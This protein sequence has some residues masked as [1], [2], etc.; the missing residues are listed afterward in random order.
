MSDVLNAESML[1][2]ALAQAPGLSD[3]GDESFR[4]GL[5]VL[6]RSLA[7]DA[8]L[9]ELGATLL[10]QKI[11]TQLANRLRIEDYFARHPEIADEAIAPPLFIVGV[12]R[13]G[14]TKLH[15]LL[16]C[17]ERF[18]WMAFWESQFPVPFP[19]E[20][21][22]NPEARRRQG[23]ELV[24]M[25]TQAMPKLLAIHPMENEAADEEVMLMEHSMLSAFNAYAEVPGYMRWLD[26]SDQAPAYRYL[27]RMLQFLQWQK[28]KRGIAAQRW[29]LKAPHHLLRMHLL[30]EVFP[31]AQVILTHR[32]PVQS[33]P[34][35]G[36]FVHTLRC[37]YSEQADAA[38]AGREW[39]EIMRRAQLHTMRVREQAPPQ[40]ID[41]DFRD[42]VKQPMTVVEK[43]Y[44]FIGWPLGDSARSAMQRWLAADAQ[45]HQGGHDYSPAQFGLSEDGIRRD[46]AEYS[47]R[48]LRD[49][50]SD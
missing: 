27:R 42:T 14:T 29:V 13:T 11:V 45:S 20:R 19:N 35:I 47:R 40:F 9:S 3:F 26:A 7:D 34:S 33:I 49:P 24:T 31:G 48:H 15:R 21:L 43:L 36:S 39:S 18:W 8:R 1:A 41:V 32:D 2:E 4:E 50:L 23:A 12:P 22:E 37:I 6:S 16:S 5:A 30:L 28:R 17:D 46:F 44:E 25:M 10:R 38:T